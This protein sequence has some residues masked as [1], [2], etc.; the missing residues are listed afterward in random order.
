MR[1]TETVSYLDYCIEIP[2]SQSSWLWG[3]LLHASQCA[4]QWK[5]SV[6]SDVSNSGLLHL[7]TF[8]K[9]KYVDSEILLHLTISRIMCAYL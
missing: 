3:G 6:N 5:T 1:H 7:T 4:G 8:F 9:G 2:N